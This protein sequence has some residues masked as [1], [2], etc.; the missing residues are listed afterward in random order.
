MITARRIGDTEAEAR[1]GDAVARLAAFARAM[2]DGRGRLPRIGDDDAGRLWPITGRDPA[3]VRDSLALAAAV[4][5]HREWA[6]WGVTEEVI[7]LSSNDPQSFQRALTLGAEDRRIRDRRTLPF[8]PAVPSEARPER[9]SVLTFPDA[10][11][12]RAAVERRGRRADRRAQHNAGPSRTGRRT[13]RVFGETGFVTTETDT[14]DH[15]VIDAGPH[16][17]LNGG[18]AHADALSVVLTLRHKPLLVDPGTP[19]YTMDPLLRDGSRSS[20][21]HNTITIDNRSSAVPAG[22]FQWQTRADARLEIVR[23]NPRVSLIEARR[24]GQG[25]TGHRRVLLATDDGYLVIDQITG[26][27]EHQATRHWHFDPRWR[28]RCEGARALRLTHESGDAAWLLSDRGSVSLITGDES[29]AMGWVSP[30]YGVRVPTWT[31]AISETQ[32]SPFTLV[33]WC[34]SAQGS[35]TPVLE[36]AACQS[37]AGAPCVA[38]R[39]RSGASECVTIARPGDAASRQP[40]SASASGLETD[41]RAVQCTLERGVLRSLSIADGSRVRV[42]DVL[43]IESDAVMPDLHLRIVGDRLELYASTSPG[44]LRMTGE[45]LQTITHLTGNTHTLRRLHRPQTA[46]TLAAA[47]WAASATGVELE[48][49]HDVRHRRVR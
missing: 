42:S 46:V 24:E 1:F 19:T 14:G 22:P 12:R 30:A 27:G 26:E 49:H 35:A 48:D 15:L 33:T 47:D 11:V 6:P 40:R 43:T 45:L 9:R 37:D 28:I 4:L 32:A 41:A 3:D 18:H 20:V 29:S 7:W 23:H 5:D 21:S 17:Y 25:G 36:R 10:G 34:G 16:G 39:I 31:A 13:T 38:V 8:R 2:A 44:H